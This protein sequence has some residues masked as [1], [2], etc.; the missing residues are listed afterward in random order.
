MV[1]D[2]GPVVLLELERGRTGFQELPDVAGGEEDGVPDAGVIDLQE[3]RVFF[4]HGHRAGGGGGQDGKSGI[5]GFLQR[6]DVVLGILGGLLVHPVGNEGDAAAFFL[7]Q[8]LHADAEGVHHL[9]EVLAQLGVVVIHVAAVEI[10]HLLVELGLLLGAALE[11]ALETAS[12]VFREGAVPVDGESR[13]QDGLGDAQAGDSVHQ[14][15]ERT[16]HA[17][18]EIGA[19]EHPVAQAGLFVSIFHPGGLDDVGH[20]HAGRAHDFAPLAVQA[21]LERLVE[22]IRI[23]QAEAFTVRTGLLGAG[24]A[25]IHRHDRTVSRADGAFHALL[26]IMGAGG[27][28]LQFHTLPPLM[29]STA[30]KAV[31]MAMP[32]A[33]PK[34]SF[35]VF[36]RTEPMANRFCTGSPSLMACSSA[37][38]LTPKSM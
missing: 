2:A 4:A 7:L 30:A 24:I 29:V 11:P 8:E 10:G 16:G 22:E 18:H 17:A 23:L 35:R 33:V 5:H 38:V 13:I 14:G 32:A 3:F 9:H 19:G 36:P 20:L 25:R 34:S 37:S 28:F 26:E 6:H 27:I 21:V 15:S 12:A 31:R 1:G